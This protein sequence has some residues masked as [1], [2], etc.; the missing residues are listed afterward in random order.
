MKNV[1]VICGRLSIDEN[2]ICYPNGGAVDADCVC[3]RACVRTYVRARVR[4]CVVC[5]C[6]QHACV[7][8]IVCARECLR[9]C[10]HRCVVRVRACVYARASACI[11]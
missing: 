4:V 3:V 10:V 7:Y 9:A 5:L 2:H 8:V 6:C 11:L 1:W